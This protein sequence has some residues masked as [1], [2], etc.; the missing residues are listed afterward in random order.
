MKRAKNLRHCENCECNSWQSRFCEFCLILL[1]QA[2]LS[3]HLFLDSA[4]FIYFAE[5]CTKITESK[6]IRHCEILQSK[7]VAI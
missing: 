3:N 2:K 7:I 5:S 1:Y 6:I 4:F